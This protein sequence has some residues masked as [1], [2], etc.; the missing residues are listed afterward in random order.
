MTGKL[1]G[2]IPKKNFTPK[3]IFMTAREK[4]HFGYPPRDSIPLVR[5]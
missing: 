4:L 2:K 5:N 3:K 1:D